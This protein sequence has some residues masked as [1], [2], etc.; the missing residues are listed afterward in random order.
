MHLAT[1]CIAALA[2]VVSGLEAPI[3][4]YTMEDI[5]W[6]VEPWN[7]GTL[8]NITGTVQ[9]VY[10]VLKEINPDLVKGVNTTT[11]LPPSLL[12]G[13]QNDEYDCNPIGTL[14]ANYGAIIDGVHY[15]AGVPGKPVQGPGPKSCGRVSCSY[16]SAITWCNDGKNTKTLNSLE[17]IA[18]C[19]QI[20][21]LHCY[22]KEE[23]CKGVRYEPGDWNCRI[24]RDEC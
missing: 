5:I 4:G 7:N 1:F 19:A 10:E 2:L 8:L 24:Y 16:N 6:E 18:D 13:A 14:S 3:P 12:Q 22:I 23:Q 15:L 17:M 11:A 21:C 9:K 20:L